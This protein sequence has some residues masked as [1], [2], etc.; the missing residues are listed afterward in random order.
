MEDA[1]SI[2]VQ[3]YCRLE[4]T[5]DDP[6]AVSE[7]AGQQLRTADIDWSSER[8]TVEEA[9]AELRGDLAQ[10]L[11]S[12]VNPDRVLEGVPGVEVRRGRWWAE[13]GPPS[14]RFQPGFGAPA[15]GG[16]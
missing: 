1:K 14:E 4:V 6:D 16:T 3:V 5:V 8:D 13:V 7:L 9:V 12:L 2:I 10:S 15:P 11:A